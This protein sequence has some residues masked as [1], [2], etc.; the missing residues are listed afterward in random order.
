M[1]F[2][3][4]CCCFLPSVLYLI[5][6]F[7]LCSIL[8]ALY[9]NS[10][11][12]IFWSCCLLCSHERCS[13]SLWVL[14]FVIV[15]LYRAGLRAGLWDGSSCFCFLQAETSSAL[16]GLGPIFI[17]IYQPCGWC[18]FESQPPQCT[19]SSLGFSRKILPDPL[20]SLRA[21]PETD[22]LFVVCGSHGVTLLGSPFKNL[23]FS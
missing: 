5:K 11:S 7:T 21:Q 15:S 12:W 19:S 2:P 3:S 18:K 23:P 1:L 14:Q 13:V 9:M 10:S 20:P 4:C 8:A 22:K 16:I 17:S 6:L